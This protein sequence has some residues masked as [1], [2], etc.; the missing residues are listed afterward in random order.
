LSPRRKVLW[1]ASRSLPSGAYSRDPVARN[2]ARSVH[3]RNRELRA[4]LDAGW[5]TRGDRLGLGVETDRI[6]AVLIE[7]AE[8]GFLPAAEGVIGD[9]HR[10]RHVDADHADIHLRREVARGIAVA[11]EDRDAV[12]VIMI[13]RQRQCLGVVL[14]AHD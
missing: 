9:W 6:R 4:F 5:P 11:G 2:D 7:V 1:I 14:G 13:G 10:D 3:G 8:A 12:A